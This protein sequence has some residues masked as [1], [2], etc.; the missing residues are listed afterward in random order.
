MVFRYIHI[1]IDVCYEIYSTVVTVHSETVYAYLLIHV[2]LIDST[3][4]SKINHAPPNMHFHLAHK[5]TSLKFLHIG[6]FNR[7]SIG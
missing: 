6:T 4:Y 5:P 3:I 7:F 2:A 1:R